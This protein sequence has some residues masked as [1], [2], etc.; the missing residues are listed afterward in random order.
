MKIVFAVILLNIPFFLYSQN[1]ADIITVKG[2]ITSENNIP[3][4]SAN[5]IN[6]EDKTGTQSDKSGEYTLT[7]KAPATIS[8]SHIGFQTREIT[9]TRELLNDPSQDTL[10]INVVLKSAVKELKPVEITAEEIQSVH[11]KPGI[12]I[13]DYEFVNDNILLLISENKK[14]RLRL[15]QTGTD[16]IIKDTLLKFKADKLFRD[17]FNSIQV[18]SKDSSYQLHIISPAIY[19]Y[20]GEPVKQ[21][22]SFVLPCVAS[23]PGYL[24][25]KHYGPHNQSVIYS[26]INKTTKSKKLLMKIVNSESENFAKEEVAYAAHLKRRLGDAH[27]MGDI[28]GPGVLRMIYDMKQSQW[29]YATTLTRPTYHPLKQIKDSIF[30]FN[31]ITDSVYVYNEAEFERAFPIKYHYEQGWKNE[32]ITDATM[33]SA[34]AKFINSGIVYLYRVS[35]NTG[36][37]LN[38]YRLEQHI[39]PENIKVKDNYAYYLYTDSKANFPQK[40]LFRQKLE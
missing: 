15:I 40:K 35:L 31:Y 13:L 4:S 11:D 30:I 37:V 19:I 2:K 7:V 6:I 24:L 8:V 33:Q 17:C 20:K 39:F 34:Y 38:Q 25:L 28:Y 36:T 5:I 18:L 9:V 32:I 1:R 27:E 23:T 14:N 26:S 21:F 22:N 3:L 12:T 16:S 10:T 29:F